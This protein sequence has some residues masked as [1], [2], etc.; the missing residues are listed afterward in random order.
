[1]EL[2]YAV[3]T[4]VDEIF[5]CELAGI[6]F[7]DKNYFMKRDKADITIVEYVWKGRGHIELNGV[8][9]TAE[10]GDVYILPPHTVQH[11]Y[12]DE[13]KP[14]I[15]LWFNMK[16]SLVENLIGIY[17]L[18]T[19]VV[20]PKFTRP[21]LFPKGIKLV[22]ELQNHPEA[23]AKELAPLIHHIFSHL[24]FQRGIDRRKE[25]SP[26]A[27]KLRHYLDQNFNKAFDLEKL[28]VI[29]NRSS[30]QAIRI[31][32]KEYQLTPYQYVLN[33]RLENAKI[34]LQNTKLSSREIAARVGIEDEYH[35]SKF[36]K[37]M[38]QCSPR[39]YRRRYQN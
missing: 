27:Y 15:K 8:K 30:T 7:R 3:S 1:M 2:A 11:Y 26:H 16:G 22:R 9:H 37:K 21:E 33:R 34:F 19:Q 29:I 20:F 10:A 25:K 14:W 38:E 18:N 5:Y 17:G 13:Q 4:Q 39:E 28:G 24:S 31:F 23:V 36:F 6:T 12:S 32:K 35:F